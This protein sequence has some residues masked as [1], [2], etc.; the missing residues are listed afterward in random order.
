LF[1]KELNAACFA[2]RVAAF[3]A[4]KE[5]DYKEL[6]AINQTFLEISFNLASIARPS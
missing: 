4:A 6:S 2:Y 3:A 1:V 5:R